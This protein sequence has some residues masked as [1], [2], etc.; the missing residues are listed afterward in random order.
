MA[1]FFSEAA[2]EFTQVPFVTYM[3]KY[4]ISSKATKL[5]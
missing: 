5:N 4:Y 1:L 2:R 3:L